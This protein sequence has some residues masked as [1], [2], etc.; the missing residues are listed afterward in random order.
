MG[1]VPPIQF[2]PL[3][4][5]TGLIVPLGRW[6]L[7]TACA[8]NV[9]WQ[10]Q[11]LPPVHM[12]VNPSA[13]QFADEDLVEDVANVLK[14][15]GLQPELLELELTESMVIQDTERGGEGLHGINEKR[16]RLAI[17]DFRRRYFSR[18][19]LQRIPL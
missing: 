3:A 12:A 18:T 11:G 7:H 16:V 6:V 14:S 19:H 8:Q 13:R 9:A 17:D 1:M 15:T 5:E 10:R 4:E 2:I